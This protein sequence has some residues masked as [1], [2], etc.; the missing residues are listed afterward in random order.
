[1]EKL[2]LPREFLT[3][4]GLRNTTIMVTK[5]IILG[6]RDI[7][8]LGSLLLLVFGA[9]YLA[10]IFGNLLLMVLVSTHQGF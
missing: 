1:M 10:T 7:N 2:T 8:I 9:V 4:V 6:F 3:F 5:V